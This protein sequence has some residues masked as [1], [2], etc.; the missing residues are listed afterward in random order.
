[1][2]YRATPFAPEEWYHCY[3]RSID[4]RTIFKNR[5]DYERFLETLYLSNSIESVRRHDLYEPSHEDFFHV[6]RDHPLVA[7]GAYCI[8][9]NHFHL[10]LKERADGG[11]SKFMHRVGT[12]FTKYFNLKYDHVGNIFIKPFRSKHI[13]DDRYHKR[14]AQYIHLNPAELFEHGWKRGVVSNV[15]YLEKRLKDYEYSSLSAYYGEK[16][17]E[18]VIL[19][20]RAKLLLKDL[21][22]LSEIIGEATEYLQ[23]TL[24]DTKTAL[25]KIEQLNSRAILK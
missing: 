24:G 22:P 6:D 19:D 2:A 11:I 4:K 7:I 15:P 13:N 9:P 14:V 20:T 5:R 12:S 21:P 8:M 1:M 18:D 23:A 16:R 25:S 17:L 3:T 10:L